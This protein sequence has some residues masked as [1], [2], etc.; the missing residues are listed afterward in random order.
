VNVIKGNVIKYLIK[1]VGYILQMEV[2]ILYHVKFLQTNYLA[3][4]NILAIM[5]RNVR[6]VD[7][8]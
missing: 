2:G 5:P 4:Y 7:L 1:C 3:P 6:M 8:N